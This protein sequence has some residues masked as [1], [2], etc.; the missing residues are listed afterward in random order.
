MFATVK[1]YLVI[2]LTA[3][4]AVFIARQVAGMNLPVVSDVAKK[5][6]G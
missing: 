2:G 4:A 1:P 3:L 6:T 5:V